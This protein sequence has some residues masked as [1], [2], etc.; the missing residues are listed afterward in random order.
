[1]SIKKTSQTSR[2]ALKR[3][4]DSLLA[5]DDNQAQYDTDLNAHEELFFGALSQL[6]TIRMPGEKK[7]TLEEAFEAAHRQYEAFQKWCDSGR[8]IRQIRGCVEGKEVFKFNEPFDFYAIAFGVPPTEDPVLQITT[9]VDGEEVVLYNLRLEDV[10]PDGMPLTEYWPNGQHITLTITRAMGA[11][12]GSSLSS[13]ADFHVR[14]AVNTEPFKET[15]PVQELSAESEERAHCEVEDDDALDSNKY[16]AKFPFFNW[17]QWLTP[18]PSPLANLASVLALALIPTCFMVLYWQRPVQENPAQQGAIAIAR[19]QTMIAPIAEKANESLSPEAGKEVPKEPASTTSSPP[20][21]NKGSVRLSH[22][23]R[24]PATN[25]N[26]SVNWHSALLPPVPRFGERKA[27]TP[28][29][30]DS[31]QVKKVAAGD[32]TR[33]DFFA[34]PGSSQRNRFAMLAALSQVSVR[35]QDPAVTETTEASLRSIFA[36][37]F[38]ESPRFKLLTDSDRSTP[39]VVIVLRYEPN[40]ANVG[41]VFVDMRD[42]NGGFIFQDYADCE[43]TASTDQAEMFSVAAESL[44]AKLEKAID[45]SKQPRTR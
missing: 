28:D 18:F 26:V 1:M 7:L 38:G 31:Y 33:R 43:K 30:K 45:H 11:S 39:D 36:L 27:E 21:D 5:N 44:V 10:P 25:R 2:A 37:A 13:G 6:R 42:S 29:D 16:R 14:I 4:R 20:G 32:I 15:A 8:P 9:D 22:A 23:K 12:H 34:Q 35:L 19:N 24:K 17:E 3:F 40:E 41:V